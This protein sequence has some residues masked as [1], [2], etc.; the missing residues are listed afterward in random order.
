MFGVST[1]RRQLQSARRGVRKRVSA[2]RA[3]PCRN[4]KAPV[5]D[6]K[7]PVTV[8]RRTRPPSPPGS[9]RRGVRKRVSA[10]RA[11]PCR[12]RKAPVTDRKAPVTDRKAPVTD[13]RRTRPPSPP[14]SARRGVRKRVSARRAE[15][16]AQK[17]K[18]ARSK[19]GRS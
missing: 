15:P 19:S 10:R 12:N 16:S 18:N 7:A 4:R 11:F 8:P 17:T 3:F 5:T 2:R 9:A 14:G 1:G 6:R 13:P